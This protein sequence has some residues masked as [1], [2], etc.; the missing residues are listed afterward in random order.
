[1]RCVLAPS[2]VWPCFQTRNPAV[3]MQAVDRAH[4]I[5]PS[6][7]HCIAFGFGTKVR[8]S[9]PTA[10]SLFKAA[11]SEQMTCDVEVQKPYIGRYHATPCKP[12]SKFRHRLTLSHETLR[13][14]SCTGYLV[15]QAG[16]R[17]SCFWRILNQKGSSVSVS[18]THLCHCVAVVEM[19]MS[20]LA[21]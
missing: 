16:S 5:G 8:S 14:L 1:M 7:A 10:S 2:S 6:W 11:Y 20:R 15:L 4:R 13:K 12:L 3:D 21:F 9:R 18:L 19:Q 17:D